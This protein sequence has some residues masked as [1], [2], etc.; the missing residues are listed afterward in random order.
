MSALTNDDTLKNALC[1][2]ISNF[3]LCCAVHLL[4]PRERSLSGEVISHPTYL[5]N[6]L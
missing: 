1:A 5:A 4:F 2:F 6:R 3:L